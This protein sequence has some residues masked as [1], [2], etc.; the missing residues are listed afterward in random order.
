[1]SQR[2]NSARRPT[3]VGISGTSPRKSG[4]PVADSTIALVET[5]VEILR[6]ENPMSARGA[7]YAATVA[8]AAP[9]TEAGY[10]KVQRLLVR[11]REQEIIPWGW[12]VDGTRWRRGASTYDGVE[13]ALRATAQVYRRS[14]WK[15]SSEVV[16]IWL[17]KEALAGVIYPVAEAW[18]VDLMVCRGYPSVSYLHQ[19]A[20][21][22]IATGKSL[23]IYYLGDFDPSGKDIVRNIRDRLT[24]FDVEFELTEL[25]VTADQIAKW[26]LPSRPTKQ[27]DTRASGFAGASVELDAIPAHRLRDLVDV[28]IRSHLDL[29]QVDHLRAIEQEERTGLLRLAEAA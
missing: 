27:T 15:R 19:A 25:A 2:T 17:E 5:L 20:Q 22:T 9:K 10:R 12:I 8:S 1:M 21:D 16:E 3:E 14:L 26:D 18:T 6:A 11:M 23:T 13:D 24:E 29:R 28:A 4:R 7:F